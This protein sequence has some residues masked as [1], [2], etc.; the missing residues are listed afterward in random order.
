MTDNGTKAKACADSRRM[1]VAAPED[2]EEAMLLR[3]PA[4]SLKPLAEYAKA[5]DKRKVPYQ[6]MVTR[7]GF[8]PEAAHPEFTFKPIRWLDATEADLVVELQ[9]SGKV[10]TILAKEGVFDAEP[11]AKAE[12]PED[13]FLPPREETKPAAKVEAVPEPEVEEVKPTPKPRAKKVEAV[14]TASNLDDLLARFDDL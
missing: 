3:V 11:A 14:E 2:I 8:N 12:E 13:D 1:A 6:A 5:L 7:V 9:D 4:G 10:N